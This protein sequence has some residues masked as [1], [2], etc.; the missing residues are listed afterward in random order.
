[1]M[2]RGVFQFLS[3]AAV[4]AVGTLAQYAVLWLG[5][6]QLGWPAAWASGAGYLLGSVV[7]YLLNYR[8]TFASG[9]SHIEAAGKF[10][11]V[12]GI[13]WCINTG[14]MGLLTG[15]LTWN[16]WLAQLL[17]TGIGLGWNFA[18]SKLWAFRDKRASGASAT[19]IADR[20]RAGREWK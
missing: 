19:M 14:L 4:G 6:V 2:P 18:G 1:M 11:I 16:I 20:P 5:A 3:F 8:F 9:K 10:Y 12:V 17:T 15:W 7:N 13:G